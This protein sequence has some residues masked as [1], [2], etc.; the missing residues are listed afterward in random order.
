MKFD[1]LV[2]CVNG[3]ADQWWK[4]KVMLIEA[5]SNLGKKTVPDTT[6]TYRIPQR[7]R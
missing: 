3:T 4:T 1:F 5:G 6:S 7:H 2:S